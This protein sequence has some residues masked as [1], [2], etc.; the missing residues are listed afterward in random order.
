MS[1]LRVC[2]L[3]HRSGHATVGHYFGDVAGAR[4]A[5]GANDAHQARRCLPGDLSIARRG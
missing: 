4:A 1:M 3:D 2:G 5:I